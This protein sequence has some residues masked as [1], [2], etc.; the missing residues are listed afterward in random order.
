M[1]QQI[2]LRHTDIPDHERYLGTDAYVAMYQTMELEA[3][4]QK[5]CVTMPSGKHIEREPKEFKAKPCPPLRKDPTEYKQ[6]FLDVSQAQQ[7][8]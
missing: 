2:P 3:Y 5:N 6:A 4:A 8:P 1:T 7:H